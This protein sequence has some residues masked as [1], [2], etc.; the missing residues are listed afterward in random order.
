MHTHRPIRSL[1]AAATVCAGIALSSA[2]A[3]QPSDRQIKKDLTKSG[4]KKIKFTKKPGTRQLNADTATWEYV[5]GVEITRD[6][7]KIDGV[8]VLVIGDAVYQDHHGKY[9]YWKFRVIENRYTGIPDPTDKEILAMVRDDLSSFVGSA[10]YNQIV[11]DVDNLGLAEDPDFEWSSPTRVS[12]RM[13]ASYDIIVSY[14]EVES[15]D[16]EFEVTLYR[17]EYTSPWKS[18]MSTARTKTSRGKTK[19]TAEKVRAM[20]TLGFRDA[21]RKAAAARDALPSVDVPEFSSAA[22]M[23]LYTHRLLR[24][25]TPEQLESFL[26]QTLS[27]GHFVE[28]SSVQLNKRGA[29]TINNAIAAAYKRTGTYAMQYCENVGVDSKRSSDTRF[30]LLAAID[31]VNTMIAMEKAGG[32][33]VDGVKVG[34]KWTITELAVRTRQ[35]ADAIEFVESFS[36]RSKLCPKD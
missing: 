29:D 10:R 22:E 19:H 15:V 18:F 16:Q 28:G 11:S 20:E 36:D 24:N 5:R 4:V 32:K 30:Y 26:L 27:A 31:K 21:E 6:Y 25:G 17:D 23:A 33:Y 14:T 1:L 8:D 12:F 9:K 7:D 3:A 35:D 2:A 34:K 13:T